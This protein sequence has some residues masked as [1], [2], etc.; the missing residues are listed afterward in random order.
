MTALI[1]IGVESQGKPE[2]GEGPQTALWGMSRVALSCAPVLRCSQGWGPSQ[3]PSEKAGWQQGPH[4]PAL[5]YG[6]LPVCQP[7][8]LSPEQAPAAVPWSR[9]DV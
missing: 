7:P 5:C 2:R 6:C 8:W 4:R 9:P 1:H 3:T